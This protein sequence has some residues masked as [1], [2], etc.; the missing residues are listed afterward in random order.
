MEKGRQAERLDDVPPSCYLLL[1]RIMA[2]LRKIF[3][4]LEI[5]KG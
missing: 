4:Q 3:I 5:N 2:I 1:E